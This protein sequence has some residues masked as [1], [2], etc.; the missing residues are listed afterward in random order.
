[1]KS[2]K[3]L[4]CCLSL[5]V[6]GCGA[7]DELVF[8]KPNPP[9]AGFVDSFLQD[10]CAT[11]IASGEV[12]VI[13]GLNDFMSGS[14]MQTEG[15]ALS[16]ILSNSRT[17]EKEVQQAV[18]D[19]VVKNRVISRYQPAGGFSFKHRLYGGGDFQLSP[20][21]E[22]DSPAGMEVKLPE[23]FVSVHL[24]RPG[25]SNDG[26]IALLFC[27]TNTWEL[28]GGVGSLYSF[29]KVNDSW[30]KEDFGLY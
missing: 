9:Q 12:V 29:R 18:L 3:S 6:L 2:M 8:P 26:T 27:S 17:A 11:E 4:L 24:S 5:V 14:C 22:A 25:F 1:M 19:L 28:G 7:E 23:S 15:S 20:F 21:L 30:M 10:F 16:Y 13:S